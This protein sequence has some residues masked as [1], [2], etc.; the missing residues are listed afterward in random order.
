MAVD[1]WQAAL[2]VTGRGRSPLPR[3][4]TKADAREPSEVLPLGVSGKHSE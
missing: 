2:P 3:G 1:L 4:I